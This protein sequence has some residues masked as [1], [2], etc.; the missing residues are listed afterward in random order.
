MRPKV[1]IT[2]PIPAGALE[3]LRGICEVALNS[4]PLHIPS[5]QELIAAVRGS[6][7]LFCLLHDRITEAVIAANP[8]LRAVASMTITPADIDVEAAT[9][10]GIPVTV[11]PALLLNDATADMGWC[12]LMTVA[13]RVA[14]ADRAVRAGVVPGAQ[15]LYFSGSPVSGRTLGIV[16]LGGVGSEMARRALGFKM[17]VLYHDP[18]RAAAEQERE[19]GLTWVP[20]EELLRRSDFVS[21]HVALSERTRHLIDAKALAAMQAQAFLINTSR[22]P[23]V[24]EEALIAA[25]QAGEI[26]GAGLDVYETEPDIDARLRALPNVVLTAHM[27]SAIAPLRA[28]MA[29]V[30][31]DNIEAIVQGRQPP[32]CWN[33]AAL[34]N[35]GREKR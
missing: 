1:Y 8:N 31:V 13:R 19:L 3:R 20:F 33:A 6:D 5:E 23:V 27:G 14:E 28:A 21:L 15:S 35:A 17:Q 10:R 30:V 34:A 2:Q 26:A 7:I 12:L 4:D 24:D 11:I 29:E 32:H 25:L 16:G 9:A 18:R 22:G